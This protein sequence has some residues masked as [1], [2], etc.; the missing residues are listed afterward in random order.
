MW[1]F[2]PR[3]YSIFLVIGCY[4]SRVHCINVICRTYFIEMLLNLSSL[5]RRDGQRGHPD[6]RCLQERLPAGGYRPVHPAQGAA[7][8]QGEQLPRSVRRQR[9]QSG[10]HCPFG[11]GG[12]QE[13]RHPQQRRGLARVVFLTP[14]KNYHSQRYLRQHQ[15][16]HPR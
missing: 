3:R 4:T 1:P 6:L 9:G 14:Q 8:Q 12:T 10:P 13:R 5:P 16:Q 11:H 7:V 2:I 15:W